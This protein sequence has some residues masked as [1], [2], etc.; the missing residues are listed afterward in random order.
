MEN[1]LLLITSLILML[2]TTSVIIQ[3]RIYMLILTI[4]TILKAIGS[5]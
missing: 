5:Y 4:A 2:L 1:S 3:G